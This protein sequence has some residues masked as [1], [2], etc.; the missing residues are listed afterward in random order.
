MFRM[1]LIVA[2]A[3]L[4]LNI[5]QLAAS[6]CKAEIQ[7]IDQIM[8]SSDL[9]DAQKQKAMDLR[10]A[11]EQKCSAGEEEEAKVTLAEVRKVLGIN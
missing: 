9:D 4:L 3:M 11:A 5:P 10:N 6:E 1:K 2:A 8:V 7:S